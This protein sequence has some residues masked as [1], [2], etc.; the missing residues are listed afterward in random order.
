MMW[1][2][3]WRHAGKQCVDVECGEIRHDGNDVVEGGK[4][5][6]R[7]GGG[8]YH[9]AHA[10]TARRFHAQGRV[11]KDDAILRQRAGQQR[12]F[13]EN[14][15]VRLAPF[16]VGG[17]DDGVEAVPQVQAVERERDVLVRRGGAHHQPD[18]SLARAGDQPVE[19]R[20][21]G[22]VRAIQFA[23]DDF[24]FS[25]QGDVVGVL[26]QVLGDDFVSLPSC[27]VAEKG[28]RVQR[29]AVA[30]K[31][32]QPRCRVEGHVVDD[33]AIHVEQEGLLRQRRSGC[34]HP[35]TPCFSEAEMNS[36]MSP[37]STPLVLPVSK[38]VRKSLMRDWS[39]T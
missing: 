27:R 37:S 5:F 16:H 31:E 20:H 4:R 30:F 17:A 33:R 13:Q 23:V 9:D 22:Q 15:R 34:V 24:L 25:Q 7:Q 11:F 2:Q 19:A 10:G 32:R 38:P 36:S 1:R 39:S 6:G 3:R 18:A 35:Y 14:V 8:A 12:A 28:V 21:R 26:A 29:M